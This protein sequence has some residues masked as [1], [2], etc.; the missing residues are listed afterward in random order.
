MSTWGPIIAIALAVIAAG[1]VA[2]IAWELSA[3]EFHKSF[4]SDEPI[5]DNESR[6]DSAVTDAANAGKDDV[7]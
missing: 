2:V 3:D 1:S 7:D 6:E 5:D 4:E